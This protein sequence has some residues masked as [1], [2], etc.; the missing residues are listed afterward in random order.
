M[1]VPSAVHGNAVAA[2]SRCLSQLEKRYVRSAWEAGG[3]L[4]EW[5][6]SAHDRA[7]KTPSICIVQMDIRDFFTCKHDLNRGRYVIAVTH[8]CVGDEMPGIVCAYRHETRP[9]A[10]GDHAGFEMRRR[11]A[12]ADKD[13]AGRPVW[14]TRRLVL[15]GKQQKLITDLGIGEADPARIPRLRCG[16]NPACIARRK[17]RIGKFKIAGKRLNRQTYKSKR[18]HDAPEDLEGLMVAQFTF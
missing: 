12:L 15:E 9:N 13:R 6:S 4:W 2:K 17:L 5:K 16:E 8:Q 7:R 3:S 1:L 11:H 14:R 10:I 18:I